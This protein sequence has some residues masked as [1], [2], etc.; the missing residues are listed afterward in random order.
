MEDNIFDGGA[1]GVLTEVIE[2]AEGVEVFV[3]SHT[4]IQISHIILDIVLP[5]RPE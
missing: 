5:L 2:D 3:V 4:Y 1:D